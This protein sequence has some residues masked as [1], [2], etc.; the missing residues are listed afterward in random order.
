MKII[1]EFAGSEFMKDLSFI[2]KVSRTISIALANAIEIKKR[3]SQGS[4][5][6][7]KTT[8]QKLIRDNINSDTHDS[9]KLSCAM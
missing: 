2:R 7:E 5:A 1:C 4:V 6:P 9:Q 8:L 3:T